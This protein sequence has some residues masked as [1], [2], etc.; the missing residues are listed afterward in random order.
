MHNQII[1]NIISFSSHISKGLFLLDNHHLPYHFPNNSTTTYTTPK[2]HLHF[3]PKTFHP[4][5]TLSC[6]NLIV[7]PPH[8]IVG[9]AWELIMYSLSVPPYNAAGLECTLPSYAVFT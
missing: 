1:S 7:L 5:L 9:S 3:V 4:V 6:A 2:T 8:Y